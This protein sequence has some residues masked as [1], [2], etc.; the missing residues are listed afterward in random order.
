MKH[1]FNETAIL[2]EE[3][4][5]IIN[6][7]DYGFT[8]FFRKQAENAG[9]FVPARVVA[10]YREYYRIAY[11]SGIT[12]ARLKTGVYFRGG[13]ENFPTAGDFVLIQPNDSGDSL[14]VKTLPRKSS[15][16][17]LDSFS[18]TEQVVAA[19][20][21]YVF[22]LTSLNNDFNERRIER[23]VAA[24]WESGGT[25]VVVLTKAD[26]TDDCSE[27]LRLAGEAAAGVH[28]AAVS[29]RTG[30]GMEELS[31][32]LKPGATIACLGSSGVGKS[33]LVN[34]LAGAEIMATKEIRE[35]DSRGR[36][37]TTHRQLIM[38]ESGVMFIDTPGMR[39]LG[40]W[41]ASD[42]LGAAFPE[43]DALL[44]QCRFSDCTHVKEPGCAIKSA[45]RSG[46]LSRE[47]WLSYQKLE[48]EARFA[49]RKASRA[50]RR[51]EKREEVKRLASENK[52]ILKY[53]EED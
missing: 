15:F 13:E 12:G 46:G 33:S 44:G 4:I 5:T 31:E 16:V 51:F 48:K 10:E 18:G 21:D 27:Q 11:S 43:I 9:G 2:L 35:D 50:A 26:L 45:L 52:K 7:E 23:Y 39:Q 37:T 24:A 30:R 19:N 29:A 17:R 36:H 25:P 14:I 6:I 47:R 22:I 34:A 49:D 32:Y 20:F 1:C 28:V 41:D 40:L 42:G 8:E 38:L 53:A 3:F